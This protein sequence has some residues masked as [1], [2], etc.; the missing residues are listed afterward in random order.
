MADKSDMGEIASF[1]KLKL[2]KTETQKNTLATKE[3]TEQEK[4]SE[5]S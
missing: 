1:N 4:Q 5:I 3:I 2:K